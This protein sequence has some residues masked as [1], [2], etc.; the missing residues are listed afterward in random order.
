MLRVFEDHFPVHQEVRLLRIGLDFFHVTP[1]KDE[2]CEVWFQRFDDQFEVANRV[3]GLGLN[4]TFQSWMV[5]SLLGLSLRKWSDLLKDLGHRLPANRAEDRSMQGAILRE[6][7]LEDSVFNLRGQA[8]LPNGGRASFL[9]EEDDPRPL[10]MCL[11]DLGGTAVQSDCA[12]RIDTE[13]H[14]QPCRCL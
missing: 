11:G 9:V 10:Y 8:R 14:P 13:Q 1:R 3:V 6:C 4:V 2:R 5:V 12:A 7:I